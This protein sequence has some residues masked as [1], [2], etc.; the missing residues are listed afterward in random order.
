MDRQ[1]EVFFLIF[2]FSD[3]KYEHFLL[4]SKNIKYNFHVVSCLEKEEYFYVRLIVDKQGV[5]DFM[6]PKRRSKI[7]GVPIEVSPFTK[8]KMTA[9]Q[10]EQIGCAIKMLD[11][12]VVTDR[13]YLRE[14]EAAEVW[15]DSPD[16]QDTFEL[17]KVDKNMQFV[18]RIKVKVDDS[19]I[20]GRHIPVG[21]YFKKDE[22]CL[23]VYRKYLDTMHNKKMFDHQY[24]VIE[25]NDRI[26]ENGKF[27]VVAI[28]KND[29]KVVKKLGF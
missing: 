12:S 27:E 15:E 2:N 5:V 20:D 28:S 24:K 25:R 23:E 3:K 22:F 26:Y 16:A 18:H 1:H 4:K 13:K 17:V 6:L 9:E 11:Y 21:E 10:I 7:V 14:I 29:L 19:Q 8:L